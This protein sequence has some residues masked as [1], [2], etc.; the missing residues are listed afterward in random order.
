M[1]SLYLLAQEYKDLET[2]LLATADEETGEVSVD[3]AAAVEKAHGTFQEKAIAVATVYRHMGTYSDEIDA[4]IK[5]LQALKKHVDKEQARV[6]DY[7]AMAC[8]MTGTESIR[9]V[10]ANISFRKSESTVID[11]EALLPRE[12]VVEKVT[13]SPDKAAIKAA[14]KAGQEV[15]GA[16]IETKRNI[17][18]K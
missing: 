14:I 18:I 15:P 13:Y 3:I 12:Y 7:L 2:A 16:R 9:G 5:R 1:S 11:D 8:E 10:Y 4:E 6:R 17:Q